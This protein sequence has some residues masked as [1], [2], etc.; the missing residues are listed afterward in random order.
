MGTRTRGERLRGA[1]NAASSSRL[2]HMR[3]HLSPWHAQLEPYHG[4]PS[5]GLGDSYVY[6]S[7]SLCVERSD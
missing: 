6:D 2:L 5:T 4:I 7:Q 1:S 3:I